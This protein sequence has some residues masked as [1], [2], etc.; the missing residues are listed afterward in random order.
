[1]QYPNVPSFP[2]VP[3]LQRAPG[4]PP[5]STAVVPLVSDA[6]QIIHAL[7]DVQWGLYSQDGLGPDITGDSVVAVDYR[8]EKRISNFPLEEGGFASYNKVAEPK[9]IRVTFTFGGFTNFGILGSLNVL[10]SG[11]GDSARQSFLYDCEQAASSLGLYNVVTREITYGNMN[12]THVDYRRTAK[13][14]ATLL[15]VDVWCEEVRIIA[16]ATYSDAK[17]PDSADPVN[18]GN[19]TPQSNTPAIDRANAA[20]EHPT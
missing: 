7:T 13:N 12:V 9:D 3:P 2:G 14:G 5:F 11:G 17:N 4:F 20:Y 18:G 19:V 1:V 16:T 6:I 10:G 15:T 8:N